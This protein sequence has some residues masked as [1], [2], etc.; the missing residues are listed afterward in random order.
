MSPSLDAAAASGLIASI[1]DCALA[2]DRWPEMLGR[3]HRRLGF[4]NAILAFSLHPSGVIVHLETAGVPDHHARR[5]ADQTARWTEVIAALPTEEPAV[6]SR[7]A[8]V[9]AM[10]GGPFYRE[11]ARPQGLIDAIGVTLTR[12]GGRATALIMGRHRD[13]GP[14]TAADVD[15]LRLFLPHLRRT[16]AIQRGFELQA[17]V[18]SAFQQVIDALAAPIFLVDE[19]LI[20]I[21]A[22]AAGRAALASGD[23]LRE[24][25]GRLRLANAATRGTLQ[26]AVNG[27]CGVEG[28]TGA[29]GRGTPVFHGDGRLSALHVMPL[30]LSGAPPGGA[31]G[32]DS[33]AVCGLFLSDGRAPSAAAAVAASAF[34]LTA[35]EVQVFSHIAAGMTVTAA[36]EAIGIRPSTVRTH[37][38]RLFNKTG[39]HRQVDL[40][41][42]ADRLGG[43]L[44][45]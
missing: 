26:Q 14:I 21:H 34:G 11:W 19:G 16:A 45:D 42:L 32:F 37:L 29:C 18:L 5:L 30:A 25:Q 41:L 15:A 9:G 17:T 36:A 12:D 24:D 31:R 43:P 28:G 6:M 23:P 33:C 27:A 22:N 39:T 35:A 44:R 3:L 13:A 20:L 4:A 10:L 38:L 8:P 1:Y 2:A 7:I 40:A